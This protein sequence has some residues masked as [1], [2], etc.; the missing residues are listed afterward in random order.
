MQD[1]KLVFG[2]EGLTIT[3]ANFRIKD[4]KGNINLEA[5]NKGELVL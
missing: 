2:A 5:N 3:G 4:E 1:S